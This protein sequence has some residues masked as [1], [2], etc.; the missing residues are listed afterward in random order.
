[1]YNE[2]YPI[3]SLRTNNRKSSE[4]V[5]LGTSAE[6]VLQGAMM[7]KRVGVNRAKASDNS[8]LRDDNDERLAMD[9]IW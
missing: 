6:E 1:V 8:Q 4:P 7:A 9:R 2:G 3:S 5:I